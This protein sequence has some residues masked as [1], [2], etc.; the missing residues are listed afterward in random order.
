MDFVNVFYISRLS[1][2]SAGIFPTLILVFSAFPQLPQNFLTYIVDDS[3]VCINSEE[4][5]RVQGLG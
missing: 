4:E 1:Y 3:S 2:I 5:L